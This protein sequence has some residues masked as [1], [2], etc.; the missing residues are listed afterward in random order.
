MGL[1]VSREVRLG[2]L[3]VIDSSYLLPECAGPSATF[4]THLNV[5]H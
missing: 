2:G 5:T 3:S 1:V 4:N